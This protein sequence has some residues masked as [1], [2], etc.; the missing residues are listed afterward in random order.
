MKLRVGIITGIRFFLIFEI[1]FRVNKLLLLFAVSDR[2][3]SGETDD[4]SGQVLHD[5]VTKFLSPDSI[6]R[7]LIP[8]DVDKIE[9]CDIAAL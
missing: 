7:A 8:D 4:K 5:L 1:H 3:S 6:T 2:C 9:V